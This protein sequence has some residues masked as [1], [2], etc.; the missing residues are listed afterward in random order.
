[1]KVVVL[2]LVIAICLGYTYQTQAQ[3]EVYPLG[4]NSFQW[5]EIVMRSQEVQR[6]REIAQH[7]VEARMALKRKGD[8]LDATYRKIDSLLTFLGKEQSKQFQL[9][10]QGV[11]DIKQ[12][13]IVSK[14]TEELRDEVEKLWKINRVK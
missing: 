7:E 14:L 3:R 2:T 6:Q 11:R 1:M 4:M 12:D 8:T 5:M 10:V 13:V 9:E